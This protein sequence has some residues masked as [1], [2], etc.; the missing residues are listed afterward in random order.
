[1]STSSPSQYNPVV[2]AADTYMARSVTRKFQESACPTGKYN[3]RCTEVA[4]KLQTEDAR[5]ISMGTAFRHAQE[6]P[7]QQFFNVFETMRRA[8]RNH[9][10]IDVCLCVLLPPSWPSSCIIPGR[11]ILCRLSGVISHAYQSLLICLHPTIHPSFR[12]YSPVRYTKNSLIA[13]ILSPCP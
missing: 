7:V 5:T 12:I 6:T 1:M 4:T 3:T 2:K 10:G 11:K 8:I 13:C 9:S